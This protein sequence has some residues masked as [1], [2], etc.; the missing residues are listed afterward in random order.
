MYVRIVEPEV[1]GSDDPLV[2][3]DPF[4]I[5][6]GIFSILAGGGSFLEARRQREVAQETQRG[7]FRQAWF[8]ARRTLIFFKQ[9]IDEF[10]TF[11]LEDSY[12]AREFRIG[13]VRLMVDAARRKQ[14][15]RLRGQTLMTANH[16]GDNLD[17]LS[18]FLGAEY[19]DR[20]QAVLDHLAAV[21]IPE[22]YGQLIRVARDAFY[23][24]DSFLNYIADVEGFELHADGD[25]PRR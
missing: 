14:M 17:D 15:R 1:N 7:A 21:T 10:E 12:G 24:Y 19:A 8:Q 11:V 2:D 4:T 18:E 3:P 16:M 9:Q 6:L 22:T 25:P 20:V 13:G 5:G 23:E